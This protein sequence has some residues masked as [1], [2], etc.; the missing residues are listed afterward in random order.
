MSQNEV[1]FSVFNIVNLNCK[2]SASG[3]ES[4]VASASDPAPYLISNKFDIS[5]ISGSRQQ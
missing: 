3:L 4:E 5:R 1:G 2:D